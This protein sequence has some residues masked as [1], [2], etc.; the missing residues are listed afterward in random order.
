MAGQSPRQT[1]LLPVNLGSPAQYEPS[2]FPLSRIRGTGT[3][4]E[5][6]DLF[7][8]ATLDEMY[9]LRQM[10]GDT[11]KLQALLHNAKT[12]YDECVHTTYLFMFLLTILSFEGSYQPERKPR[13]SENP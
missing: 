8:E 11:G 10:A 2:V 7:L 12:Q 5:Q 1:L 6:V 3:A 4:I 9:K 13:K